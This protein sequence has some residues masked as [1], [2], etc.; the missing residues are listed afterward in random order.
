[1]TIV[2]TENSKQQI[3]TMAERLSEAEKQGRSHVNGLWK[4]V[5]GAVESAH[6]LRVCA[7]DLYDKWGN[8][9][10]WLGM[11]ARLSKEAENAEA[12]GDALGDIAG[13]KNNVT[14]KP[15]PEKSQ[16]KTHEAMR[17]VLQEVQS[18]A[19]A[20]TLDLEQRKLIQLHLRGMHQSL[21]AIGRCVNEANRITAVIGVGD[22][23]RTH[24]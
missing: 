19:D 5:A 13:W 16:E 10:V 11:A 23:K 7:A 4:I 21:Q 8:N 17:R 6:P 18:A 22:A 20:H 9:V 12:L 15:R 1:M 2:I 24:D 14:D 3:L